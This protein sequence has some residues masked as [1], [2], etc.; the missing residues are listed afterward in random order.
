M[1][2]ETEAIAHLQRLTNVLEAPVRSAGVFMQEAVYRHAHDLGFKVI[3]D[4][5]GADDL[6]GAFTGIWHPRSPRSAE[7]TDW[8]QPSAR[9]GHLQHAAAC[10]GHACSLG[11]RW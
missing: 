3:I 1:A 11:L 10:V 7:R 8:S 9:P 6:L 5:E 2:S 4:G